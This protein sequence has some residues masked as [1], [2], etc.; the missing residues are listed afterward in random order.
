MTMKYI[1]K[2]M[3]FDILNKGAVEKASSPSEIDELYIKAKFTS[4]AKDRHGDIIERSATE[5][6]LKEYRNWRNIRYMHMP[7][8]VG[9]AEH[10]GKGDG[11]DL[12][13]NEAIIRVA[14]DKAIDKILKGVLRALSVGILVDIEEGLEVL[15]DGGWRITDY[16]LAEISL[17]D[18]PANQDSTIMET[19]LE[20]FGEK[21]INISSPDF[22]RDMRSANDV[23]Q[24]VSVLKR[25]E[26]E[27]SPA[28]RQEGETKEECKERKI[29]EL[30]DEGY[31]ED[32]AVAAA[33][34]MCSESC[35]EK[36]IQ[37]EVIDMNEKDKD[38]VEE[39]DLEEE[40]LEDQEAVEEKDVSEEE[41]SEEEKDIDE[42]EESEEMSEEEKDIDEEEASEEEEKDVVEEE[43]EVIE[44]EE[45]KDVDDSE[46]ES[47]EEK[48]V[49][50]SESEQEKDVE[51]EEELSEDEKLIKTLSELN[52]STK[53][54]IKVSERQNK[55]LEK[56][57]EKE[58]TSESEVEESQ[59]I[60]ESEAEKGED[61]S[62]DSEESKEKEATPKSRKS[63]VN[64]EEVEE[65]E[66]EDIEKDSTEEEEADRESRIKKAL[67]DR[68]TK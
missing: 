51:E 11:A 29:P 46:E 48:D 9:I 58:A 41:V 33:D 65:T 26:V 12:D 61:E 32:Q 28:C 63:L 50:E 35:S 40:T 37:E 68:F 15:E 6:A 18:S 54:L 5:K 17:V 19:A 55:L 67:R 62:I 21:S 47:E 64:T 52:N 30:I 27:K 25:Y 3:G 14:D 16:M 13:W 8:P 23:N 34:E 22:L 4:D 43:E 60:D 10:I 20:D 31:D 36:N 24:M 2:T 1:R 7:D 42:V 59:E 57:I 44:E 49:D 45:E 56:M 39:Q 66:D 38:L 53:K